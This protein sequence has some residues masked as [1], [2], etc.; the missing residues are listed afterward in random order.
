MDTK[1]L[2]GEAVCSCN[3]NIRWEGNKILHAFQN[4]YL[5]ILNVNFIN[6]WSID[7]S[8]HHVTSN[9]LRNPVTSVH[10]MVY[11]HDTTVETATPD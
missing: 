5:N 3:I 8:F 9:T 6:I 4:K 1:D 2:K 11:V 7:D 10:K